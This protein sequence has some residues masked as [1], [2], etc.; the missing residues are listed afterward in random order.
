MAVAG[1]IAGQY[2]SKI[3]DKTY[4]KTWLI[5]WYLQTDFKQVSSTQYEADLKQ[6]H[7]L[8]IRIKPDIT[9]NEYTANTDI[10]FEMPTTTFVD[11]E[12]D[13]AK[14]FAV[15]EDK[16]ET[17][18]ADMDNKSAWID[19]GMKKLE[20]AVEKD[21]Y[22]VWYTEAAATNSGAT[23]GAAAIYNLGTKV[24]PV[25]LTKD[26]ITEYIGLHANVLD[27]QEVPEE[28]RNMVVPKW[29][30][31]LIVLSPEFKA[32]N[33]T[34]D[35]KT[36]IRDRF[37]GEIMQFKIYVS[38]NLDVETDGGTGTEVVTNIFSA[39]KSSLQF[40]G[41]LDIEGAVD[42]EKTFG[43]GNKALF[44]YGRKTTKADGLSH[45]VITQGSGA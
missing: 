18:Q 6:G 45:G 24:A 17:Q 3:V 12:I 39:H 19:D 5:K 13:Q 31:N 33:E 8:R 43:T 27:D 42:F 40:A 36:A 35:A 29:V 34:G 38:N 30:R 22:S 26:N 25:L 28:M 32:A 41:Q 16:I 1:V 15:K 2:G 9:I 37:I 10:T 14:Y 23:A 11:M 20:I 7:N 44:V 21:C 4:S